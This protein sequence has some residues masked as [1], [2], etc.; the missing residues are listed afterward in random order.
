MAG[1]ESFS[2]PVAGS[3]AREVDYTPISAPVLDGTTT[4]A[5]AIIPFG[6]KHS[7]SVTTTSVGTLTATIVAEQSD[8]YDSRRPT[9]ARWAPMTDAAIVA[10]IAGAGK[11]A[12]G[13]LGPVRVQADPL[14]AKAIRWTATRTAGTGSYVIDVSM[15]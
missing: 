11:P 15:I 7:L 1:P 12:G 8:N 6:G 13:A 10:Y 4:S 9:E 2:V 5:S 3:R 14:R